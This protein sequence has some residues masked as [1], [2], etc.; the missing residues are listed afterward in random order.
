MSADEKAIAE[1]FEEYS[2]SLNAGDLERWLAIWDPDG[3]QMPPDD[4]AQ[5]GLEAIRSRNGK[6]LDKYSWSMSI[7]LKE[8]QIAG[9]WAYGRGFYTATLEPKR[10]GPEDLIDGKFLT[11]LKRQ[12]DGSW[13]FYRDC[14]NSNV[15]PES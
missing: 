3:V 10:E 9:E 1:V 6:Y 2:G 7:D 12:S 5:F 13:R 15:P 14:F 11:I 4:P 8:V